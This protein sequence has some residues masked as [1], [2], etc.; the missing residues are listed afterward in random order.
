M[1][2]LKIG[3]TGDEVRRLQT[4]LINAGYDLG[5]SGADGV[6]GQ[7][8]D[9]AVKKYQQDNN[10]TV[11][12]IAGNQTLKALYGDDYTPT[13]STNTSGFN[14]N[15]FDPTG[16]SQIQDALN[17]LN[18]NNASRPGDYTPVWQDE[19]DAF[20]NDYQNRDPFAYNFNEDAMYQMYKDQY[21]QQGQLASMDTMAQAAAMTGGYGNSYAQTAGQMVYNQQLNQLNQII[22]ELAD[23]AYSRYAQEG[24]DML[25]MYNLYLDKEQTEYGRYQDALDRWHQENARLT[26]NYNTAY[27]RA[28][29]QYMTG[30]EEAYSQW[31]LQQQQAFQAAE[32]QKDRDFTA[33]QNALSRAASA[34]ASAASAT[35]KGKTTMDR[36][37][38]KR[39]E[40]E[41]I[42]ANGDVE[43]IKKIGQS[44]IYEGY[45]EDFVVSYMNDLL[46]GGSQTISDPNYDTVDNMLKYAN[47]LNQLMLQRDIAL[48]R[49]DASLV[50]EIFQKYKKN[51]TK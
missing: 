16:Y 5:S 36:E 13:T 45:D 18:Q 26:D 14:Y 30:R 32:A 20:L 24:Q 35:S 42:G 10:L 7:G 19:A 48:S 9:T 12:G 21:V 17:I 47:S 4:A 50:N 39:V 25:N 28:Y 2:S 27:D 22:P 40:K 43:K 51:F 49:Y 6:F 37:T 34:A 3:S 1:A 31:Q 15:D 44:L 33:S 41:L 29:N 11:D 23:M 8:T 38:Q 46:L